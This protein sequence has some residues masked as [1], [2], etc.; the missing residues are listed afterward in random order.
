MACAMMVQI[1]LKLR[2]NQ[3]QTGQRLFQLQLDATDAK[4]GWSL[5]AAFG[6]SEVCGTAGRIWHG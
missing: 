1:L 3:K 4:R 2:P 5:M 6:A